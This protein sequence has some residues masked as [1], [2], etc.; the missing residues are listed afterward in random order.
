MKILIFSDSHLSIKK[1]VK[2]VE[3]ENPEVVICGGDHSRDAEELSYI[4]DKPKYYIVRGNCDAYDYKFTDIL[5]FEL[6]GKKIFLTHGHLHGV[7]MTLEKLKKDAENSCENIVIFGHTHIPHYE[8]EKD[9]HYFNPGSARDGRYGL[10]Y[11][12]ENTIK[13]EH[14]RLD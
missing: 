10:L 8:I 2:M 4:E 13:F 12:D 7:K 9:I 5:Q 1:K 6:E 11:L 3:I 14:K